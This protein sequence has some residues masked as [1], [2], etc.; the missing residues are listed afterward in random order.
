M[1]IIIKRGKLRNMARWYGVVAAIGGLF[2]L[3]EW[4]D[5]INPPV[6][7]TIGGLTALIFGIFSAYSN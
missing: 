5:A 6:Y 4:A 1:G 7:A 3:L 2:A